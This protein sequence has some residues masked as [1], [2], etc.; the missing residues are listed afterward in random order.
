MQ[1]IEQS[2]PTDIDF[3]ALKHQPVWGVV[4]SDGETWLTKDILYNEAQTYIKENN[5]DT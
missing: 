2:R 1:T 5:P 3:V 4:S